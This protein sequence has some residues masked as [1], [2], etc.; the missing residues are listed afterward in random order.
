MTPLDDLFDPIQQPAYR[1]CQELC[2]QYECGS[3]RWR[4]KSRELMHALI[5]YFATDPVLVQELMEMYLRA[6]NTHH[7]A[8]AQRQAEAMAK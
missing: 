4:E 7:D 5:E 2:N 8:G 3:D 6:V 1:L